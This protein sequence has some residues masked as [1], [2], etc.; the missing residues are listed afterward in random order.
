MNEHLNKILEGVFREPIFYL[1]L[2][3]ATLS[4]MPISEIVKIVFYCVSIIA[5]I[6][7][8]YKYFLEIK[9]LKKDE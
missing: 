2:G 3:T 5:T 8:T 7:V 6:V 1:N 4:F 9:K